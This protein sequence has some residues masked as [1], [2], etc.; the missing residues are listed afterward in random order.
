MVSGGLWVLQ[1]SAAKIDMRHGGDVTTG[2]SGISRV[3]W[4]GG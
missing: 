4:H 3:S 2:T 1:F